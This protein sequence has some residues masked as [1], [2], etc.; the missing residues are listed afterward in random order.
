LREIST[1]TTMVA[2]YGS[3]VRNCDG[4]SICA[5]EPLQEQ[6]RDHDA[7]EQVR[8]DEH[9]QRPPRREH[10][11]ASAIQPRPATIPSTHSGV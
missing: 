5:P 1:S 9:A 6:L 4:M 11:E 3:D 10:D 8:A 7:A 2:Q